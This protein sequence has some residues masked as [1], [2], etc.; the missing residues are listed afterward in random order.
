MALGGKSLSHYS[1]RATEMYIDI[2]KRRPEKETLVVIFES[3]MCDELFAAEMTE[4]VLKLHQL[5]ENIVL[6]VETGGRLRGFEI[7]RQPFLDTFHSG[8]LSKIQ[9]QREVKT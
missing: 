3:Q 9:K 6:G 7:E 8:P 4:R 1:Q 2:P 5:D